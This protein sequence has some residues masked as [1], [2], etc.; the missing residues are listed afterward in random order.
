VPD[1][2][3]HNEFQEADHG[4]G[5]LITSWRT[6]QGHAGSSGAA[7]RVAA[8]RLTVPLPPCGNPNWDRNFFPAIPSD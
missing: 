2:R 1:V 4:E 7:R 3:G 6:A 5:Y 8:R